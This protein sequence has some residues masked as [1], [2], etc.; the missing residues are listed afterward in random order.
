MSM[1][2]PAKPVRP[3]QNKSPSVCSESGLRRVGP[4]MSIEE[5]LKRWE[6]D[7]EQREMSFEQAAAWVEQ[8]R[9]FAQQMP[10]R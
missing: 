3:S 2:H 1:D 7:F 5:T 9:A 6:A 4:G 8:E 10:R